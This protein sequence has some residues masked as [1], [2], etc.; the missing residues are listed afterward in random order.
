MDD[1]LD[2]LKKEWPRL[3]I[4][5][6]LVLVAAWVTTGPVFAEGDYSV[7]LSDPRVTTLF[8][9]DNQKD[10]SAT[11]TEPVQGTHPQIPDGEQIMATSHLPET[12]IAGLAVTKENGDTQTMVVEY[13]TNGETIIITEAKAPADTVT[14]VITGEPSKDSKRTATVTSSQAS[15]S[16]TT[17]KSTTSNSP[18]AT[19]VTTSA[20]VTTTKD[21]QGATTTVS[22][23]GVG[24]RTTTQRTTTSG[25]E[26][27]V[28]AP[29]IVTQGPQKIPDANKT[30]TT[31]M[32]PE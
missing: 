25:S 9:G 17:R 19:T 24:K 16:T 6:M 14:T 4:Y 31:E 1:I 29:E 22:V 12:D 27:P 20:A 10:G 15:K 5:F 13:I 2:Y 32:L 30:S 7:S 3:V 8:V 26:D 23:Q 11:A 21:T 28:S 18:K